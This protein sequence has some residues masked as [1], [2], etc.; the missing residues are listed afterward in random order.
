M[1]VNIIGA[2]NVASHLAKKMCN[3]VDICTV[4]SKGLVNAEKLAADVGASAI[5]DLRKIDLSA[6]LTI[7]MVGDVAIEEVVIQLPKDLKVVHTS[8]SIPIDVFSGFKNCGI[9][10]PLQTFSKDSDL[11]ISLIPFLIEANNSSFENLIIEFC[12]E[13][14]S[15]NIEVTTSQLRSEIHLAAVISN[16]F[17]THLLSESESILMENNLSLNILSPLITETIKKAF[18]IGPINAQTGPAKRNDISIMEKQTNR[19]S[20]PKL[21]QVYQL[22]SELIKDTNN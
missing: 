13:F 15:E 10:Y 9:L 8:G 11:D 22:I 1:K 7:V 21:K 4:Y 12:S 18:D 5:N 6:D 14:L 17:I 20:N 2:G 3:H 16:N 19:I